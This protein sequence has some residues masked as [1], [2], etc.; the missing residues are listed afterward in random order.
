M[1]IKTVGHE[2]SDTWMSLSKEYDD[3]VRESSPDLTEW[4]DGNDASPS[5]EDYRKSKIIKKR[6]SHGSK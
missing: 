2:D 1:Q 5:F 4:Y 6:S 3:Y